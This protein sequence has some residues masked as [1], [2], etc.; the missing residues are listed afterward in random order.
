MFNRLPLVT[1]SLI[2]GLLFLQAKAKQ[3]PI[4]LILDVL[5]LIAQKVTAS[6]SHLEGALN[7]VVAYA[8]HAGIELTKEVAEKRLDDLLFSV[9]SNT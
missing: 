4:P 6:F 8:Q 1:P 5:T 3:A 7:S 9:S 2:S